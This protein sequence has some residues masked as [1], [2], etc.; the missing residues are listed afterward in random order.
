MR[1]ADRKGH[2]RALDWS[3]RAVYEW[4]N[5]LQR[6]KREWRARTAGRRRFVRSEIQRG[7][8]LSRRTCAH[9]PPMSP[10]FVASSKHRASNSHRSADVSTGWNETQGPGRRCRRLP[11][12]AIAESADLAGGLMRSS[13]RHPWPISPPRRLVRSLPRCSRC[14]VLA[15]IAA[16]ALRRSEGPNARWPDGVE[17]FRQMLPLNVS[18]R[19]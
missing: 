14:C 8:L 1:I 12:L 13:P 6:G 18:Q 19:A 11:P 10:S 9:S 3:K 5:G 16:P 2:T 4:H 15:P 7:R 17:A